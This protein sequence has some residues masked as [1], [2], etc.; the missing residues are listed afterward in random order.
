MNTTTGQRP[1]RQRARAR[2][3]D[4]RTERIMRAADELFREVPFEQLTLAAVAER[5]GV[6]LQTLIRRVGTKDGL[7]RA[8][9]QHGAPQLQRF[10]G[11]IPPPDPERVAA[12]VC[13]QYEQMGETIDRMIRQEDSS[14]A[15]K[16]AV[17]AGRASHA[18]WVQ[19]TFAPVLA[20]R[21][22]DDRKGLRARLIAVTGVEVYLVIRRD[23]GLDPDHAR[24]AVTALLAD[25]LA[26]ASRSAGVRAGGS[27]YAPDTGDGSE[28]PARQADSAS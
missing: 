3:A 5:A 14:P 20:E 18:D 15:L 1:Y 27:S 21:P 6:G 16:E 7:V 28:Q 8:A 13:E 17:A 12:I 22:A 9:M 26:G 11:Q 23:C 2:A 25:T 4:E 19:R 24:R 10:R